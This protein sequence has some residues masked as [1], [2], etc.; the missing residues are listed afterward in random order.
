[1]IVRCFIGHCLLEGGEKRIFV[2]W[3]FG[4]VDW[5]SHAQ[6][7]VALMFP[8]GHTAEAPQDQGMVCVVPGIPDDHILEQTAV[9]LKDV[10]RLGSHLL[11]MM[12][13]DPRPAI[14]IPQ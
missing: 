5:D 12:E 6:P 11:A 10:V 1:M 3:L 8:L 2:G 14:P 7:K 13:H 9:H 4:W